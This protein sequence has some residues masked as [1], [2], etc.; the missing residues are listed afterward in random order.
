MGK[1]INE[2]IFR[3]YKTFISPLNPPACRFYPTCS[4]YAYLCFR[5]QH[6]I[7]ALFNVIKR[8]L[9]CNPLFSGGFDAPNITFSPIKLSKIN[10]NDIAF[11]LVPDKNKYK[12]IKRLKAEL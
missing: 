1:K 2:I 8:I 3:F 5:F 7:I 9:K 12:I 10:P 6:P 4:E 11:W